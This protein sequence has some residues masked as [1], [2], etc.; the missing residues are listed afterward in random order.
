MPV[1]GRA[2][3][4]FF[5]HAG[6]QAAAQGRQGLVGG[7][8]VGLGEAGEYVGAARAVQGV[9]FYL[10][11]LGGREGAGRVLAQ[12]IGG[13]VGAEGGREGRV[14]QVSGGGHGRGRRPGPGGR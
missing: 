10:V 13:R 8:G 5:G 3:S 9:G 11:L 12:R 2:R 4:S 6:V 14:Q 7:G 1:T